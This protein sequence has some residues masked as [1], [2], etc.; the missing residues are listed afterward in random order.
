MR[1]AVG[2]GLITPHDRA[3]D[4][5]LAN[6]LPV[7]EHCVESGLGLWLRAWPSGTAA[8]VWVLLSALLERAPRL[9]AGVIAQFPALTRV[10][11]IEDL[12][13]VDN[14]S[15]GRIELAIA[16]DAEAEGIQEVVA[17]LG[18]QA[19]SRPD[20]EG[21]LHQFTVTPRPVR[22]AIPTWLLLTGAPSSKGAVTSWYL[23][24]DEAQRASLTALD[25]IGKA[26]TLPSASL[27]LLIVDAGPRCS[28]D[29]I[30][31]LGDLQ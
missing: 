1:I 30:R 28:V 5:V 21:K 27:S 17:G 22:G 11:D 13:V 25:S 4:R 24:A 16:P 29:D 18:G 2:I 23:Q 3:A 9:S 10:S 6:L 20:P 31:R 8:D 14:L 12:L 26:P 7:A 19:L 15:N